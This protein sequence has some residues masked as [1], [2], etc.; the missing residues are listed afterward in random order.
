MFDLV[1]IIFVV[2]WVVN[3]ATYLL[4]LEDPLDVSI[5][6]II[7]TLLNVSLQVR[8]IRLKLEKLFVTFFQDL[9]VLQ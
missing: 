5:F 4:G 6:A 7:L 3:Q 1:E 2:A 8:K 9:V